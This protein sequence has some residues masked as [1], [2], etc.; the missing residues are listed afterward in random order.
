MRCPG[1]PCS[2]RSRFG[3]PR[4]RSTRVRGPFRA[5]ASPLRFSALRM[6]CGEARYADDSLAVSH[7]QTRRVNAAAKR[8]RETSSLSIV[9]AGIDRWNRFDRAQK[10]PVTSSATA[11]LICRSQSVM[12]RRACSHRGVP[13]PIRA[14]AAWP[15]EWSFPLFVRRRSWGSAPF[16]G[17][18]PLTGGDSFLSRRAHLPVRPVARPD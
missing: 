7:V 13:L 17:L 10:R 6:R 3:V 16:A 5:M 9:S 1:R 15:D 2:G 8:A 11:S 4:R 14:F 12:H 18:L